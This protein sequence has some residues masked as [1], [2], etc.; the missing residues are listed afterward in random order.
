MNAKQAEDMA[1][2]MTFADILDDEY[3]DAKERGYDLIVFN[4]K[5]DGVLVGAS[6]EVNQVSDTDLRKKFLERC[7]KFGDSMVGTYLLDRENSRATFWGGDIALQEATERLLA[8]AAYAMLSG[9]ME[10]VEPG[11]WS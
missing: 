11:E 3:R 9:Q 5:V 4:W 2:D 10:K 6:I 8:P 1:E 7:Q